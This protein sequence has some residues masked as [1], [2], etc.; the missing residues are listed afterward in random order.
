MGKFP[1]KVTYCFVMIT[2]FYGVLIPQKVEETTKVRRRD[3]KKS[4]VNI[5]MLF[6]HEYLD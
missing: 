1:L 3:L 4:Y 5:R 2:E 6:S